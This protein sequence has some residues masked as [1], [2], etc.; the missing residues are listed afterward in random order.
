LK[1]I[2]RVTV[3]RIQ[4][5]S[6]RGDYPIVIDPGLHH[7]LGACLREV[8]KGDQVGLVT[9]TKIDRLYGTP[10]RRSLAASG[11]RSIT[12]RVPDGERYKTLAQVS[13][14]YDALVRHR[15]E[16][17]AT[18]IALGGGVIGDMAGFAAA[19]YLRGIACVQVPTT[20]VAQ[21]DASIGGKTG[22]DHP[23]GKNLIGAFH[24]PQMVC[25][26]P[27]VLTTLSKREFVAGLAEVVKYG[28]I[29]DARFFSDLE[30]H[31]DALVRREAGAVFA[32]IKRA[33][34][35]KAGVV[36]ADERESGLRKI[37]NYGHTLGHALETLTGYRGCRHGEAVAIGMMFAARLS[38][39]LGGMPQEEVER[40]ADLLTRLSLPTE[41]PK[42]LKPRAL[43]EAM[44]Q[45]KKVSQ[46]EIHFVLP[47]K[48]G[49]TRVEKVNRKQL[50]SFLTRSV[51]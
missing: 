27:E 1:P 47:E 21:V 44:A 32:C 51:R 24:P 12:L 33:A 40:Q 22:V 38:H 28:V 15:F 10:V 4:V 8:I 18:L 7:R 19:T 17:G 36:S 30:H 42:G 48:I 9:H 26:D 16:R 20:V 23:K 25:I 31:A 46:G 43:L 6:E 49:S 14:I 5:E 34:E 11:F 41:I 3:T 45:D 29:A 35:M 39:H 2:K 50:E 13:R 37:L